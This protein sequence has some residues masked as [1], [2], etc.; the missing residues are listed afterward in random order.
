MREQFEP[1]LER[2]L[3]EARTRRYLG[4]RRSMAT[5]RCASR[6]TRCWCYAPTPHAGRRAKIERFPSR[7]SPTGELSEP[8]GLLRLG[9]IRRRRRGGASRWSRWATAPPSGTEKLQAAGDYSEAYFLHGLSVQTA[10]ATADYVNARIS[11]ELGLA[12]VRPARGAIL[13]LPAIP[14]LAAP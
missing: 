3:R 10:E 13:G 11:R 1:R 2:M 8:G 14:E 7:A 6:A 4:H 9:R 5:S 12:P